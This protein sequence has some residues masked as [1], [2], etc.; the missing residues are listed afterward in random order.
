MS[1]PVTMPSSPPSLPTWAPWGHLLPFWRDPL[2]LLTRAARLGR[3]VVFRVGRTP[4]YLVND[5]DLIR[6][7]LVVHPDDYRQGLNIDAMKPVLGNSLLTSD[8]AVHRAQRRLLQPAFHRQAVAAYAATMVDSAWLLNDRWQHEFETGHSNLDVAPALVELTMSIVTQCLFGSHLAANELRRLREDLTVVLRWIDDETVN[9]LAPLLHR[10]PVLP[11]TRR[12]VRAMRDLE[13]L[14]AGWIAARAAERH[15]AAASEGDHLDVLSQ[16]VNGDSGDTDAVDGAQDVQA[17]RDQ[18]I[19]LFGAG[20]ETTATALIWC[21]AHLANYPDI[22]EHLAREV[23]SVL[24]D[25]HATAADLPRLSYAHAVLA[26]TLRLYPPAWAVLRRAL[27]P[28][29]LG[30]FAIPAGANILISQWL[31]QRDP[32]WWSNPNTFDPARWLAEPATADRPKFAYFPFGGGPRLC[33]GE[34]FA[35]MEGTLLLATLAQRWHFAPL[36]GHTALV[37]VDPQVTLRPKG[38]VYLSI[39]PRSLVADAAVAG[40]SG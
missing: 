25:R 14:V 4:F 18:L 24:G 21:C 15:A 5:P 23:A 29:A 32:T 34:P 22:Q 20:H 10:L 40:L 3:V 1:P 39:T 16:L 19:T 33:I 11:Q 6:E 2:Y 31:V 17:V 7:I 30:E 9:P 13:T 27:I 28:H 26:E 35:W 38:G 37:P 36:P 12:F 8:G